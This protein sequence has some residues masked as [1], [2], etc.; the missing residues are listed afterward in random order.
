[1]QFTT[2]STIISLLALTSASPLTARQEANPTDAPAPT[3]TTY[4]AKLPTH[5]GIVVGGLITSTH[6]VDCGGCALSFY[7]PFDA[8]A[9]ITPAAQPMQR[10]DATE[11][12][13]ALPTLTV[14]D[15]VCATACA[16]PAA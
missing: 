6:S 16:T 7:N 3:C 1:M 8:V 2:I 15:T 11:T 5:I 9:A 13:I 10:R 12:R 14:W 4:M